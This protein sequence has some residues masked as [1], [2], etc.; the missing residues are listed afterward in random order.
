MNAIK[1]SPDKGTVRFTATQ[2]ENAIE[3][4]V[5]DEGPGIPEEAQKKLFDK[6][7]RVSDDISKAKRG[8]GLGL[9]VCKY[10]VEAHGGSIWVESNLGKGSA[11]KFRLP[12]KV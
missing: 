12:D 8:T 1:S 3:F 5:S 4:S 11:F 6:F 7:Y 2:V 10:I 9:T